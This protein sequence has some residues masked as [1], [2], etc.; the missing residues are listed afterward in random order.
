MRQHFSNPA[1]WKACGEMMML[2]LL[3]SGRDDDV[4]RDILSIMGATDTVVSQ[5]P[6]ARMCKEIGEA[7]IQLLQQHGGPG[8]LW[9]LWQQ[10]DDVTAEMLCWHSVARLRMANAGLMDGITQAS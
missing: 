5:Q 3:M 9:D 2:D 6:N 8:P 7:A 4:V 10:R 1:E